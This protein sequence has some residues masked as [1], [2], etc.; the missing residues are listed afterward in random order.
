MTLHSCDGE[1]YDSAYE[2]V[3]YDIDPHWC[4][5]GA[6]RICGS[7]IEDGYDKRKYL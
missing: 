2:I 3:P 4:H 7:V 1:Y 6:C 5:V